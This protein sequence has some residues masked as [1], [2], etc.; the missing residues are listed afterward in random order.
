MVM[1][2]PRSPDPDATK[3]PK[4]SDDNP[5]MITLDSYNFLEMAGKPGELWDDAPAIAP[6]ARVTTERRLLS[7][8][9]LAECRAALLRNQAAT[10]AL[11]ATTEARPTPSP[12]S[13]PMTDYP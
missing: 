13:T 8:E 12:A 7:P 10:E 5:T 11:E 2:W 1:V 3:E 4:K 6:P 9:T